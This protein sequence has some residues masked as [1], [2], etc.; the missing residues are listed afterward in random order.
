MKLHKKQ[1]NQIISLLLFLA[2]S[3]NP[4][5]LFSLPQNQ[6]FAIAITVFV[7]CLWITE[8][9]A[10]PVAS[11]LLLVVIPLTGVMPL[12]DAAESFAHPIIFLFMGGFMLGLT[13]EK[14][15]FHKRIALLIVSI[16]GVSP[17]KL[18]LSFMVSTCFISMWISNTASTI[19]ML[20]IAS[21]IISLLAQ[22]TGND[23]KEIRKFSVA[24]LISIAFS[25]TVGGNGTLIGSPPNA[26]LAG[27]LLDLYDIDLSFLNWM[28]I[29]IPFMV[30]S[31]IACYF[32]II[33]VFR[34][35]NLNV[36]PAQKYT[37]DEIKGLGKLTQPEIYIIIVSA[38][39]ILLLVSRG[40]INNLF[41]TDVLSDTL[42]MISAALSFFIL[43]VKH[44]K[45]K[46]VLQWSDTKDLSWG[47]LYLFGGALCLANMLQKT[48][49]IELLGNS[50]MGFSSLPPILVLGLLLIIILLITEII[51]GTAICSVFTPTT[52]A[53][54]TSLNIDLL[55]LAVPV[56]LAANVAY[57]TPVATAPNAIIFSK[58]NMRIIDMVKA[59]IAIKIVS[60]ILLQFFVT[61][62]IKL[63][64]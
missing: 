40:W 32:G 23:S 59:G 33:V 61:W 27:F 4:F 19:I 63:I 38:I 36:E 1:I 6:I 16:V 50:V 53:I 8:A 64:F 10:L 55:Y 44:E 11:L 31:F 24:L 43:P 57:L 22:V 30:L 15:Q 51:G 12:K 7:S 20:P 17:R 58:G 37:H 28:L 46:Y 29:G 56:T 35:E 21:S 26:L 39:A 34:F 41:N 25:A 62:W 2:I 54:A 13:F 18:I 3:I 52:L 14:W 49:I 9:V 47:V 5:D 48:G 45:H 42:I 60:F